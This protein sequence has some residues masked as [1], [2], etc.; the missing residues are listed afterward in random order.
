VTPA[1]KRGGQKS[2][3]DVDAF[4]ATVPEE[5]RATLEKLRETIRAAVPEAT[6]AISY[7]VPA[8]KHQGRPLV[9]FGATKNHCAF[10][11]MSP[12]VMDAHA[13][14]LGEYDTSKGTI[15]F[16][17]DKPLPS[18]LVTKLVKARIVENEARG[19]GYGGKARRG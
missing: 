16:P 2:A 11:L 18:A 5:A 1:S 19:S 7:G 6:E 9:A 17:H 14:E 8:F 3:R 10:Y 4:L 12:A 15:R 13:A